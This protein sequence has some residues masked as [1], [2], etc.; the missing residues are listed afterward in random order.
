[1]VGLALGCLFVFL[2]EF[3][4]DRMHAEK[5]LKALLPITVMAEIPEIQSPLDLQRQKRRL[6]LGWTM[7]A[8]VGA[9]IAAGSTF[10]FLRG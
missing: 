4:D 1:M 2:L 3:F 6:V 5:E 10:S 8:I 7:A 9:V